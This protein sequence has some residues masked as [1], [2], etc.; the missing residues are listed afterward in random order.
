MRKQCSTK[1]LKKLK[2]LK[3]SLLHGTKHFNATTKRAETYDERQESPRVLT[4]GVGQKYVGLFISAEG[5]RL[6]MVANCR[7]YV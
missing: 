1:L 4:V 7:R 6:N 5:S 2:L 3:L